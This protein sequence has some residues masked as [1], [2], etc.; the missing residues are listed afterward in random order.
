MGRQQKKIKYVNNI[1]VKL[2]KLSTCSH[3]K[4]LKKFLE[5][6]RVEFEYVDIDLL[7][8]KE[9]KATMKDLRLIN[10]R[11]TLPTIQ[12]GDQVVVGFKEDEI[13]EALGK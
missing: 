5:E 3:C 2:Y 10:P 7:E 12:I 1:P 8:K 9:R 6:H 4:S 11:G 13:K